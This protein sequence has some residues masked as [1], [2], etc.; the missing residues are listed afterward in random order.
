VIRAPFDRPEVLAKLRPAYAAAHSLL[1]PG[2]CDPAALP[3]VKLRKLDLAHRGS[4]AFADL[5]APALSDELRAFAEALTGARLREASLRLYRF[6]RGGYALFY[7]DA[8]TRVTAGVEV[9]LDLSRAMSGPPAV[10]ESDRR[11]AGATIWGPLGGQ[12][13]PSQ[14]LEVPQAPGLVAVVERGPSIY[15]SDRYL[16]A[17]VG[18]A[19]VL[20]L[21]AAFLFESDRR[22]EGA[23]G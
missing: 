6:R 13:G 3:R 22:A 18:R 11:A 4:Y 17:E 5:R 20:R 10:Y 9:T 23:T 15:R 7:D 2:A 12:G 16:P 1:L 14:R 8:L 19:S 21:R